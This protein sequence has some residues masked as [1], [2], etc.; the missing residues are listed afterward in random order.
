MIGASLIV[1]QLKSGNWKACI[2][3]HA[4]GHVSDWNG[5]NY[6]IKTIMTPTENQP[7]KGFSTRE[8][9]EEWGKSKFVSTDAVRIYG[10][11][12]GDGSHFGD[13]DNYQWETVHLPHDKTVC[14]SCTYEGVFTNAAVEM[15]EIPGYSEGKKTKRKVCKKHLIALQEKLGKE[16]EI[17]YK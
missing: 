12:V 2:W 11:R 5:C 6:R 16:V 1:K 4:D 3:G 10:E 8:E 17:I 13:N 7:F 14:V 15:V 9:A